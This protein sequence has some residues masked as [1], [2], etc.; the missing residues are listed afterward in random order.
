MGNTQDQIYFSDDKPECGD[1]PPAIRSEEEESAMVA[2]LMKSV[3]GA[4]VDENKDLVDFMALACL[5]F[6]RYDLKSAGDRMRNYFEWRL[7]TFGNLKPQDASDGTKLRDFLK[8]GVVRLLPIMG[9][10]GHAIFNFRFRLTRPDIFSAHD[11]VQGIHFVMMKALR[12]SAKT[13]I[14]GIVLVSDMHGA[15]LSNLDREVPKQVLKMVTKNMPLRM[16]GIFIFRPNFMLQIVPANY[17]IVHECQDSAKVEY[18][19]Q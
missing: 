7:E 1:Q 17:E 8:L 10:R 2:E 6:R 3:P 19:S 11:V 5:R 14:A 4:W 18:Y 12:R 13:Q 9:P 16:A 15:G